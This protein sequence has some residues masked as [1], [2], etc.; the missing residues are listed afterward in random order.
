MIFKVPSK[1]RLFKALA[2][3]AACLASSQLVVKHL[4]ISPTPS[5]GKTLFLMTGHV[6]VSKLEDGEIVRFPFSD[7]F[8]KGRVHLLKRVG[9]L[10]GEDLTVDANKL[11]YC[12]GRY[13]GKAKAESLSGLPVRNFNYNGPV[14][15]GKFFAVASHKDSYDSRYYGFVDLAL[16]EAK[17]YSLF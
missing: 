13:L 17:A 15:A 10:P 11:Y 8:T 5:L 6:D 4:T 7:S 12:N 16:I 1:N 3:I 2:V 14:P 9:C